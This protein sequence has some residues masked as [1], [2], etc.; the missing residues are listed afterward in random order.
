LDADLLRSAL[1]ALV[2]RRAS[3]ENGSRG[4]VLLGD[5][6]QASP[7][8][9]ADLARLLHARLFP[10]RL[11]ATSRRPLSEMAGEGA[12]REDL[13]A[14]LST[15][16]I[17]LPPLAKRRGDLP[18][19][20]QLFLEEASASTGKQLAGFTAEAM[21]WLAAYTWPG[22]L[23]ELIQVVRES[24]QRAEGTEIGADDLPQQIR[25]ALRASAR[26]RRPEETIELDEFLRRVEREL[27]GRA[28]ARAKGNKTKAARLLG[29][30]R[31][32][33]Y[34]RLVQLGLEEKPAENEEKPAEKEAQN[35]VS[36]GA[37]P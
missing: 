33:L 24:H 11:L 17:V 36:G 31:P 8:A 2:A 35:D 19:L 9:Q 15:L 28:M 29:M 32:R 34:R 20:V 13:A 6:D 7:E 27:V 18:L 30:T 25:L 4:S 14:I 1:A 16:V 12:Y 22:N 26:P 21:D 37:D 23:D 10:L 5:V 3:S